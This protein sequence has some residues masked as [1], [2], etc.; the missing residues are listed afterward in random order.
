[1]RAHLRLVKDLDGPGHGM[2]CREILR[3]AIKLP[4]DHGRPISAPETPGRDRPLTRGEVIRA[5]I[6]CLSLFGLAYALA[7]C[8]RELAKL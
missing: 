1:M 8:V 6:A 3:Q 4:A 7:Y 5:W 2:V